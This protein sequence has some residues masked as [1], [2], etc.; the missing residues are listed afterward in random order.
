VVSGILACLSRMNEI[1]L[2]EGVCEISKAIGGEA[3][4]K[5]VMEQR[6]DIKMENK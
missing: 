1:E 4:D 2:P 6:N 3:Y 5:P